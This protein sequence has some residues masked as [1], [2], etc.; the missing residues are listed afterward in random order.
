M[1]GDTADASADSDPMSAAAGND[2]SETVFCVFGTN[3]LFLTQF[4]LYLLVQLLIPMKPRGYQIVMLLALDSFDCHW[5]VIADDHAAVSDDVQ[6][7]GIL[8]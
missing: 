1:S 3:Y 4:L 7:I 2:S 6:P 8:H 5:I